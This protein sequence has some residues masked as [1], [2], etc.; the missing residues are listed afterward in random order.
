MTDRVLITGGAG[1]IGSHVC[2]LLLARGHRVRALDKLSPQVHGDAGRPDHLH[3]DVEL[4][5]G[6]V[7]DR[8][9]VERALEGVDRVLHLAALVGVGQSMYDIVSYTDVNEVGTAVLLEALAKRP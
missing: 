3:A 8:T 6:D 7:R 2:D 5:V 9:L 4:M 1:F